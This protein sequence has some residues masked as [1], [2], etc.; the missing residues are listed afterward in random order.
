MKHFLL[1]IAALFALYELFGWMGS[2]KSSAQ[3]QQL[4][5]MT[6]TPLRAMTD[7]YRNAYFYLLGFTASPSLEPAKVGYEI[8]VETNAS[9]ERDRFDY[10]KPGRS[11]LHIPLSLAQA[12]P[13]WQSD[14]PLTTFR[15]TNTFSPTTV[16]RYRGLVDRYQHLIGMPFEDWGYGRRAM[17]RVDD[18]LIAH[19]IFIAEGIA[20]HPSIALDRLYRDLLFWRV[21]LRGAATP[22][23]KVMAQVVLRD[24]V[25]LLSRIMAKPAVDKALITAGLQLTV[26]LTPADYSLRWPMQHQL[27]LAVRDRRSA[28]S[29]S[30]DSSD[31]PSSENDRLA[32]LA[33]LPADAFQRIDHP[34]PHAILGIFGGRPPWDQYIA[35]YDALMKTPLHGRSTLP[36]LRDVT[37]RT[38]RGIFGGLFAQAAF[39]PD[40]EPFLYQL[41][42]TDARLRLVSLQIQLRRPS[43][44]T[45]VPTRLAE[46]GSQYYDPFTDLP[47]LWSPTQQKLY[48]VGQDRL[49]DGGDPSFDIAVSAPII[50][51]SVVK[52]TE[53]SPSTGK[54]R[55]SL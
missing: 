19:R 54:R 23:M 46:V 20:R 30:Q 43:G 11:D 14:D 41:K 44:I 7:P 3:D 10:E 22:V 4:A 34:V 50:S 49:D 39:E 48:S 47:M 6:E 15:Q 45:A 27:V 29:I 5:Q 36:K 2:I 1:T 28:M 12:T 33:R 8:W 13:W 17:P 38:G 40:W 26:P 32:A 25:D 52:P 37:G 55:S 24:D 16:Q 42:E 51:T 21:V 18:V 35:Y 53:S 31:V 9:S